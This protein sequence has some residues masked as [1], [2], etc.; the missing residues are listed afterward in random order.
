MTSIGGIP[1]FG[2]KHGVVFFGPRTF[3]KRDRYWAERGLIHIEHADDNTYECISVREFMYRVR[4]M[5]DMLGNSTKD[6]EGFAHWDEIQRQMNFRE[7]AVELAAK[8]QEQGMP[9]R[10]GGGKMYHQRFSARVK[11]KAKHFF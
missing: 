7:E 2:G 9:P 1:L 3:P 4:G 11:P 10:L 5:S 8:A 6:L